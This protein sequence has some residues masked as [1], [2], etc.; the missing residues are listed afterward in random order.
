MENFSINTPRFGC[1]VT[2][3]FFVNGTGLLMDGLFL[4]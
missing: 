1:P 2:Q 3:D 4:N